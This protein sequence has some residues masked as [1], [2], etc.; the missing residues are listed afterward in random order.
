[1]GY[2]QIMFALFIGMFNN[3][4][5]KDYISAIFDQ[6]SWL[7]FLNSLALLGAAKGSFIPAAVGSAMVPVA[8]VMAIVILLF[9]ER[10]GGWGGRIGMGAF[11][12]F[13]TVFYVGDMLSYVRLMALGM[14]S[15]G[16]GMAINV[17]VKLCAGV[18]YAGFILAPLMFV[19][20]HMFNLALS[21]LSAFVHSLRLQFV[22]FFP[23]FLVGGG[24]EF[25]PLSKKYNYVQVNE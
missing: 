25:K 3:I 6:V 1:M 11:A 2:I 9:S 10:Q 8:A 16:F 14:V 19:V 15:A 4:S 21:L 13:G 5:K 7:I 20:G 17:L 22:E 23:K 18:P 24:R 12:L